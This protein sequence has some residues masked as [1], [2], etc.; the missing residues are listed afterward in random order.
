MIL[1]NVKFR[2]KFKPGTRFVMFTM[3]EIVFII[4]DRKTNTNTKYN[5]NNTL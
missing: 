5:N 2:Y 3:A 1:I 4:S